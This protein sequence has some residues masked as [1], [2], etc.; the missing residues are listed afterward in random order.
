MIT[1]ILFVSILLL[2]SLSSAESPDTL[3]SCVS[4]HGSKG[5]GTST[6]DAPAL[7]GQIESYI[8]RQLTNYKQRTRINDANSQLMSSMVSHLNEQQISDLARYFSQLAVEQKISEHASSSLGYK[9]YQAS[10]GGC[11]GAAAQGNDIL[12]APRLSELSANY[13]KKQMSYFKTGARG[14][15]SSN[16]YAIQMSIMANTIDDDEKLNAIIEYIISL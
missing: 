3:S 1:R 8:A 9:Y 15:R 6:S 12:S 5:Q 14:S 11:H 13:I 16:R 10:C 2:S 4:C 7:A